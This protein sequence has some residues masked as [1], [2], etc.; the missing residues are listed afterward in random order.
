VG[1]GGEP[2]ADA[3]AAEYEGGDDGGAG[4]RSRAAAIHDNWAGCVRLR[5]QSWRQETDCCR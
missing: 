2:H 4:M 3:A 1:G 5:S